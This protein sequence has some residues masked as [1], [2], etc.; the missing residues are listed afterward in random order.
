VDQL[1]HDVGN[2]DLFSI[3][4]VPDGVLVEFEVFDDVLVVERLH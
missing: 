4:L 1:A 3:L 2:G